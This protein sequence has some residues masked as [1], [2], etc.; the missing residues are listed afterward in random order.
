MTKTT[1]S[2]TDSK[3]NAVRTSDGSFR[4]WAQRARMSEPTLGTQASP[5]AKDTNHVHT[6][7]S[8]STRS[9]NATWNVSAR[10][11]AIGRTRC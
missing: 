6:G 9:T 4:T 2:R 11:T 10:V 7:A 8:A 3:A 1:S 5:R